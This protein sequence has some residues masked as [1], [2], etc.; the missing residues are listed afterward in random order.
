MSIA[1]I[2]APLTGAKRDKRVLLAAFAAARPFNAHVVGLFVCSDPRL[3]MPF[4][5]VQISPDVVQTIVDDAAK[6]NAQ[7]AKTARTTFTETASAAGV[8][9]V[10]RPEKST[11]EVT[12]SF[13]QM[14]GYFPACVAEAARLSDLVVFG[15]VLKDDSPDISE[16]FA[17]VLVKTERPVLLAT[18]TP[19]DFPGKVALAWDGSDTAARAIVGA[20]PVLE[21]AGE[22]V[23]LSCCRDPKRKTDF[24]SVEQYLALHG[25]A[26]REKTIDPGPREIGPVLLESAKML[27]SDLLVMGGYGH[28][29]LGELIF[30]GVTQHVRWH[31]TMPVLMIH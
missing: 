4:I 29:H 14:E 10:G 3:S 16:A 13:A 1:R 23:L 15:P 2:I 19:T 27:G 25:I 24:R 17:E 20:L 30:G 5:G 21:K 22:V 26:C 28:S 8:T 9:V 7:A 31:A 11:R 12:C 6:I 18:L